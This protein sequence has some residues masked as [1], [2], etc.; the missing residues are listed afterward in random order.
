[1]YDSAAHNK[2]TLGGTGATGPV[3]LSN[4]AAG[5]NGT[6]AVNKAQLDGVTS[7]VNT[8]APALKYLRFGPS[9]AQTA[10]ALGTDS[11]AI[12]GNAFAS[13]SGSLAIGLFANVS[14]ANSVAFGTRATVDGVNSV[15][16]GSNS[17]ADEDN[18]VSVG[19]VEQQ[20]RIT[21]VAAGTTTTDAVNLGQVESLISAAA[22][23]SQQVVKSTRTL[24][25]AQATPVLSDVVAV[26]TTDK[27]GQAEANGTDAVAIGLGAHANNDNTVAIGTNVAAGGVG[28]VAIGNLA[29]S[30]GV[31]ATAIGVNAQSMGDTSVA[32]GTAV[33]TVGTNARNW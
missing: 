33:K 9:T 11:I 27:L 8:I 28:G 18:V 30:G 3:T 12:G 22:K 1:M 4:V 24:L 25:G 15:A 23:P 17:S 13:Q 5:V 14:G 20:R 19:S 10:N 16:I 26:G 7:S 2:I 29:T 21:N 32:I 31:S 6:D